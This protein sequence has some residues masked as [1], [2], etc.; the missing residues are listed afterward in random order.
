[1]VES[2]STGGSGDDLNEC[3]R[4]GD[5]RAEDGRDVLEY[6]L[7]FTEVSGGGTEEDVV[8]VEFTRVI[9]GWGFEVNGGKRRAAVE[10]T[11]ENGVEDGSKNLIPFRR[12][13]RSCGGSDRDSED[14]SDGDGCLVGNVVCEEVGQN[15]REEILLDV[16]GTGVSGHGGNAIVDGS[17]KVDGNISAKVVVEIECGSGRG[18]KNVLCLISLGG[19][20]LGKNHLHG[21]GDGEGQKPGSKSMFPGDGGPRCGV[22]GR[23]RA[24]VEI[25]DEE[26]GLKDGDVVEAECSER[27]LSVGLM[28]GGGGCGGGEV[29]HVGDGR[30]LVWEEIDVPFIGCGGAGGRVRLKKVEDVGGVLGKFDFFHFKGDGLAV[31]GSELSVERHCCWDVGCVE[32]EQVL[33]VLFRGS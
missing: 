8:C 7:K 5:G 28:V 31:E 6:N 29:Q 2:I 18:E 16:D 11:E 17:E 33:M 9:K 30:D 23:N 25:I 21:I 15:T 13:V 26:E 14:V 1:M 27:G 19:I 10:I 22:G 24:D 4:A 3:L 20:Q 12:D 32:G